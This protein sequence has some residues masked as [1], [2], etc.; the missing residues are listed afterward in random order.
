MTVAEKKRPND[1]P[2]IKESMFVIVMWNGKSWPEPGRLVHYLTDMKAPEG[3]RLW[4]TWDH[5]LTY[6]SKGEAE[7]LITAE[8]KLRKK[9]AMREFSGEAITIKELKK[10]VKWGYAE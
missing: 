6:R 4:S 5:A 7:K 1:F 2:Q 3:N 8:M 10:K 9:L